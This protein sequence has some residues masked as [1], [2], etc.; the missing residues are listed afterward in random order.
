MS[1]LPCESRANMMVG[2]KSA[3][4]CVVDAAYDPFVDKPVSVIAEP[5]YAAVSGSTWARSSTMACSCALV[6]RR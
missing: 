2:S 4:T 5:T 3:S 1:T 6:K